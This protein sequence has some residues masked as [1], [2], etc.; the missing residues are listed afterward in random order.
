VGIL[1]HVAQAKQ[2]NKQQIMAKPNVVG[3]GIGYRE[4]GRR[5]TDELCVVALVR[6]K[7]PMSALHPADVVPKQ[8]QDVATD[9]LEVGVLRALQARTDRWRPAPG[10]VSIG[11]Y[12]I[13]AGT[14]ACAVRDRATGER[15]IL[16]NNHVLANLNDCRVGDPI[17]QPG[18]F[19]GGLEGKDMIAVLERYVELHFVE[20]PPTCSFARLVEGLINLLAR[21]TGSKHRLRTYRSTPSAVNQVD[22]ALARPLDERLLADEILDIGVVGGITAAQLGMNVRKSGRSSG[23]TTGQVRVIDTTLTV[24]YDGRVATFENQIMTGSMS[25]PGDSGALLVTAE[26]LLAVGLLFAGSQQATVF[27]PIQAVLNELDVVL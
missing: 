26:G 18:P 20:E 21:L 16:S 9:V 13:T 19:D 10:G 4:R 22:A 24:D 23:Y 15:L 14:L 27:H 17:L 12:Q 11:H 1:E 7:L 5:I 3:V 6:R 25:E 2:M 8:V